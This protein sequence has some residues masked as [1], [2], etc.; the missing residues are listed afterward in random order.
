MLCLAASKVRSSSS[1]ASAR[2]CARTAFTSLYA[3]ERDFPSGRSSGFMSAESGCMRYQQR[4]ETLPLEGIT[5]VNDKKVG[6]MKND[7][8]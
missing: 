7:G 4:V 5:E 2:S 6:L 8:W 3:V 1:H